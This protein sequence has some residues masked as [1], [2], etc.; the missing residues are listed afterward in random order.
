M[1]SPKQ[2]FSLLANKLRDAF[3]AG[4]WEAVAL[5][6]EKCRSLVAALGDGDASDLE[7]REQL[8]ELSR[9]YDELQ[10]AGRAERKRLAGELRRLNQSKQVNQAYKPLG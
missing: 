6:D 1:S 2:A 3:A 4:D 10:Q 5:L 7:L 8:A 9:V